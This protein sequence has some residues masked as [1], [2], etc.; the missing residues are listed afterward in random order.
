MNV[1]YGSAGRWRAPVALAALLA[2][3]GACAG[4]PQATAPPSAA[5]SV[6]PSESPLAVTPEPVETTDTGLTADGKVLIRWFVGLGTGGNPEQIAAQQAVVQAFNSSQ[7]RIRLS[8]EIYQNDTAY[9]IL[10]TQIAAGRPP[11]IIGPVGFRGFYAYRDN[12]LDLG[13]LI[14]KTGYDLSGIDPAL[15][16]VYRKGFPG[17]VGI[18]FAIFPSFLYI[19]KDLFDEAGLPYPPQKVG[20]PYQGK[21]W[22]FA[23]LTEI[24]KKLTVDGEGN[25]A[26]AAAFDPDDIVQFGYV[27]QWTDPRGW[28]TQFGAG[29]LVADDGRTAQIPDHWRA[30]WKWY[31]DGMW[32][33]HFIPNQAYMD[34]DLLANGNPFQSGNVAIDWVHLWYT[35]CIIPP[36]GKPIVKNWDI[37]VPPAYNGTTTAKLHADSFAIMKATKHPDEAFEAL[38]FLLNS[39]EL[40]KAYGAL[41]AVKSKQ[42]AFFAALDEKFAPNKVNWQVALDML[43]YPDVP[44]HEADMP[45]FLKANNAVGAFQTKM[46][47]TEG[48]NMD[49]EIDALRAELQS[50]FDEVR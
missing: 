40:F 24:A 32:S 22:D 25:D 39:D 14:T 48:L 6:A 28:G 19:N 13:P 44:S 36:D 45:N 5:P 10:S 26:T 42:A 35:C 50:I 1:T 29:S 9:D 43:G 20:E 23:A 38:T 15:I 18:P 21:P 3:L 12:L 49:Q 30:A 4:T 2:I 47:G 11:D 34:S 46:T 17:Q 7:D 33:D 37:A 16:D 31:Y 8:L 27:M 41:P